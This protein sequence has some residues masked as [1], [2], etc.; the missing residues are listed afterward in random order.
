[1]HPLRETDPK[2]PFWRNPAT[3]AP[4]PMDH[5]QGARQPS[6]YSDAMG[7]IILARLEEGESMTRIAAD[8][9][10]P[11]HRTIYVWQRRHP[12]FGR[13]WAEVRADEALRRRRAVAEREYHRATWEKLRAGVEGRAPRRKMGRRSS[14]TP[15][16]GQ[17]YCALIFEGLTLRQASARPG[18]PDKRTVYRW[19]RNHPQFRDWYREAMWLR[20]QMMADRIMDVVDRVTPEN[21][22]ETKR[23]VK[24]LEA[25]AAALRPKVWIG[26]TDI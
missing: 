21:L 10:M 11:S 3:V 9:D 19:L 22:R 5:R 12:H 18:M 15:E 25:R 2:Q 23:I 16:V 26:R 7:R 4:P 13:A 8:P 20:D 17:T 24:H 14:F 1:M 6:Q